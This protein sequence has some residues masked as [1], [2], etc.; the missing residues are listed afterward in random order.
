MNT[1]WNDLI[2]LFF[3]NVCVICKTPL[4]RGEEKICITC[5]HKLPYLSLEKGENPAERLFAGRSIEAACSF[6]RYEKGNI[7]QRLIFNLKYYGDKKLGERLGRMAGLAMCRSEEFTPPDLLIPVPLHKSRLRKRGYNQ[8]EWIARGLCSVWKLPIDTEH[9]TRIRKT[10]TQTRK[11]VYERK[12]SM[13]TVFRVSNPEDLAGKHV[14]L[15]DDV[16]TSGAT[17]EACIHEL[18]CCKEIKISLFT[19]SIAL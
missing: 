18:S 17:L 19:L 15:I 10:N 11:N 16:M 14:L 1:I 6:L 8:S 5:L 3:P 4:V 13:E 12:K 7:T 9:L 2:S